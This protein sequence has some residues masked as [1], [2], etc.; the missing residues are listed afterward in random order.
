M[1]T[2]GFQIPVLPNSFPSIYDFF[3]QQKGDLTLK[4]WTLGQGREISLLIEKT[5]I[6]YATVLKDGIVSIIPK[7]RISGLSNRMAVIRNDVKFLDDTY[8]TLRESNCGYS[9]IIN[10]RLRG[11]MFA[12]I[13][14]ARTWGW[15]GGWAYT[16]GWF[17]GFSRLHVA[18]SQGWIGD[19]QSFI[20]AGDNVNQINSSGNTP[21]DDAYRN[22]DIA[23]VNLLLTNGALTSAQVHA[24]LLGISQPTGGVPQQPP[25]TI[26]AP[27]PTVVPSQ[28]TGGVPQQPP[29]TIGA[30]QPTVVPSQPTGGVPQ[31]P[32]NP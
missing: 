18:V 21:L 5:G 13:V 10:T 23:I 29:A 15:L 2:V 30:P 25:A 8:P 1:K 26:G 20:T 24:Q 31:Q 19:V 22:N 6:I 7:H 27:Q 12:G 28:P 3:S 14:Q 32:G 17:L 9:L 4:K 16:A 11:G